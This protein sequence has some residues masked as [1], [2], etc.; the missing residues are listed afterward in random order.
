MNCTQADYKQNQIMMDWLLA[1]YGQENF[2]PGLDRFKT[3]A[4][5]WL[6]KINSWQLQGKIKIA[7]IAGT[8]GKGQT[9]HD[10]AFLLVEE[11]VKVAQWTSPHILHVNERMMRGE[12]KIDWQELKELIGSIHDS[13]TSGMKVSFYEFLFLVF[14]QWCCRLIEQDQLDIILLEVG[15]GGRFDA[16]N[17]FDADISAITSISR[18]HEA[19]LGRGHKNILREKLG[20]ARGHKM[21]IT[22]LSSNYCYHL[23]KNYLKE[24]EAFHWD[25]FQMKVVGCEDNYVLRNRILAITLKDYLLKGLNPDPQLAL[26]YKKRARGKFAQLIGRVEL[27][28]RHSR[29]F[30]FIGAHNIDG[31][32]NMV[33]DLESFEGFDQT[34][35]CI[36]CSFSKRALDEVEVCLKLLGSK[37][38]V[39]L[40]E[41][42]HPKALLMEE[43]AKKMKAMEIGFDSQIKKN[44]YFYTKDW[45]KF[46]ATKNDGL[47]LVTGSYYFIGEFKKFLESRDTS[48]FG[49]HS[50]HQTDICP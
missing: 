8:N 37:A 29:R 3:L 34:L 44:K 13:L 21:M 38:P 18:D 26:S 47:T 10:L 41:F 16:V 2:L 7:T 49:S 1:H 5:P 24:I 27:M 17:I 12:R 50:L 43:M 23:A 14:L 46:V 36:L 22:A 4:A 15:L 19:I 28:T 39:V 9:T 6:C 40:T 48:D 20:V 25:L 35:D 33:R 32:R 30:I 45:K 42:E 11:G 31:V